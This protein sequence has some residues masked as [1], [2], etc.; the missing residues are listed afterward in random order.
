[1]ASSLDSLVGNLAKSGLEKLKETK[2]EFGDKFELLSRK[3]IYPYENMS[4]IEK[5]KENMLPPKEK[6][7]SKL[8]DC[9]VSDDDYEYA[10]IVWKE[11]GVKNMGEYRDL[12]LKSDVLLL[13]DV[14][15]EFRNVCMEN[16]SLDPAWYY[17]SP[18]L[19][20]DALLKLSKI[21]LELLSDVDMLLMFEKGIRGRIAMIP[22]RYGKSN[23]K[24]MGEKYDPNKST[25]FIVYLDANNLYGWAMMKPLPIGG[26][27]W[28]TE[29]E[30]HPLHIGGGFRISKRTA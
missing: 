10:Q 4:G 16:Y 2:K 5:F 28:M 1:M 9:G 8:N 14:F 26:F 13:A 3:E 17:T 21:I 7:Y 25:K 27:K 12:Y 23:N 19:S 6:L 15:E 22:N 18:G 20:W 11:L 30:K 29:D 24:Y